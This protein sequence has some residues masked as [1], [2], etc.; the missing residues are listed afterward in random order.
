MARKQ[1][2]ERQQEI[3]DFVKNHISTTGMPQRVWKLH[4]KSVSNRLMRQKSI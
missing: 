4:V 2:T 3:F 1:L